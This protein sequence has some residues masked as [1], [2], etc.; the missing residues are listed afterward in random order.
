MD[1]FLCV[2]CYKKTESKKSDK[3]FVHF[4]ENEKSTFE[5]LIKNIEKL[6]VIKKTKIYL[7]DVFNLK[8]NILMTKFDIIF[9][10]PPFKDKNV[11]IC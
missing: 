10:D 5:I 2:C 6:K 7:N 9:C 8:K 4:I 11:E 3:E 1:S